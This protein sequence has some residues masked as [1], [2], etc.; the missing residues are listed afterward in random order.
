MIQNTEL[1]IAS[2]THSS[3]DWSRV[4]TLS[5][6]VLKRLF[7]ACAM[8]GM[9]IGL[10]YNAPGLT[11]VYFSY[12]VSVSIDVTPLH[13]SLVFP[14]VTVCNVN[15]VKKSAWIK[16]KAAVSVPIVKRSD[17]RK[18]SRKKRGSHSNGQ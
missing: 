17:E 15:P 18:L 5:A 9:S 8:L 7:W 1:V 3:F 6:G 16:F 10:L 11:R 14:A 4:P 13:D 2:L 12:P